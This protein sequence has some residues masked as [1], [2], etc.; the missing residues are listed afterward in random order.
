MDVPETQYVRFPARKLQVI[1]AEEGI[2]LSQAKIIDILVTHWAEL[3]LYA[4]ATHNNL[5]EEGRKINDK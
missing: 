3:A 5:R 4:H 2:D 1:L